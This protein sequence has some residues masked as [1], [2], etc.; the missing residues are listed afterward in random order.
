MPEIALVTGAAH[1]IGFE[2]VRQL[3]EKG[4]TV[5]LTARGEEK[6]RVATRELAEEGLDVRFLQLD[7]SDPTSAR[8]AASK[9]E[10]EFG[11]LNV[12]VNNAAAYADWSETASGADLA[13]VQEVMNTNLFGAWRTSQ[14]F[15]PC[16]GKA[17]MRAS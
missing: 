1:G 3:A 2:V 14:A 15:L 7:V 16:L 9:V 5:I 12:L 11:K 10:E 17:T 4:T 8:D 6:G 13:H